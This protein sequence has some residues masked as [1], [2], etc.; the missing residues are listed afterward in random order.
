MLNELSCYACTLSKYFETHK[1]DSREPSLANISQTQQHF[2]HS[3]WNSQ[4]PNVT[5]R[6]SSDLKYIITFQR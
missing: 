1:V 2:T 5:N 3:K 4:I 6:I